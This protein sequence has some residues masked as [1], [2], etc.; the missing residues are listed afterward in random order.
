MSKMQSPVKTQTL[1]IIVAI[2]GGA[3]VAVSLFVFFPDMMLQN[4][5]L[6]PDSS[7]SEFSSGGAYSPDTAPAPGASPQ[8]SAP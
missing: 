1:V 8:A 5:S 6:D 2:V 7:G 4:T 3:A